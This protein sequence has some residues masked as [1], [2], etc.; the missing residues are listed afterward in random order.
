MMLRSWRGLT[1]GRLQYW[2]L[3]WVVMKW[4]K[5][6]RSSCPGRINCD[7]INTGR[8]W[9]NNDTLFYFLLTGFIITCPSLRNWQ[10][11][12]CG[13]HLMTGSVQK[14]VMSS[15]S[16]RPN[17]VDY[18]IQHLVI[19]GFN[20]DWGT[21]LEV[22]ISDHRWCEVVIRS[23]LSKWHSLKNL[24]LLHVPDDLIVHATTPGHNN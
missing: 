21:L 13:W 10:E 8:W 1:R 9:L 19:I 4:S 5:Q 6:P 24:P 11:C 14:D 23:S 22:S 17:F 3:D 2:P 12:A 16:L 20:T 7:H 18:S 15:S